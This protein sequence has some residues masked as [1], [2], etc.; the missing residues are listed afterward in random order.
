MKKLLCRKGY[1]VLKDEAAYHKHAIS[2]YKEILKPKG[3]KIPQ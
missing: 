2:R 3:K 1:S